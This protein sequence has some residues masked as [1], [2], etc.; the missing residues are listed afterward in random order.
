MQMCAILGHGVVT[1]G[2]AKRSDRCVWCVVCGCV[3]ISGMKKR[4]G[5]M[6]CKAVKMT[7]SARNSSDLGKRITISCVV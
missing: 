6:R 4:A 1:R 7:I 5:E 2:N 3:K